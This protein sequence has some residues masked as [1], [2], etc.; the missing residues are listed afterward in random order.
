MFE[1]YNCQQDA[2][3][4][5]EGLHPN[6]EQDKKAL[7]NAINTS[8][9]H[10]FMDTQASVD[11]AAQR[12]KDMA[13]ASM[14]TMLQSQPKFLLFL[15]WIYLPDFVIFDYDLPAACTADETLAAIVQQTKKCPKVTC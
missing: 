7:A 13:V 2:Y 10:S 12:L 15:C 11:I 6:D 4:G 1:H 5:H 14:E 8:S 9:V 3:D